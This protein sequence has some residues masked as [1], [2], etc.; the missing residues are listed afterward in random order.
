MPKNNRVVVWF[1]NGATSAVAWKLAVQE[2]GSERV[3][4]AMCDTGSEHPDNYRFG[5]EVSEW[6]GQPMKILKSDKYDDI[7]EVFSKTRFLVGAKGARCTTELKKKMRQDFQRPD[8]VHVFGYD[9]GESD[10]V[11]KFIQNNPELKIWLPLVEKGLDKA[12]CL[13]IIDDAGIEIPEMYKLGYGHNNCVGCVKGGMGYWNK[14]REDFPEV[15]NRM[16]RVERELGRN[17]CNK[18]K[19]VDGQRVKVPVFLDELSPEDGRYEEEPQ[20][21]CDFLCGI[22]SDE[23]NKGGKN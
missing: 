14:I 5:K 13:S 2:F 20:M 10:R 8:D 17:I 19:V 15:F 6:V 18:E 12:A 11:K 9:A 7:W 16:A 1:S 21:S 23:I 22:A 4:A 3:V